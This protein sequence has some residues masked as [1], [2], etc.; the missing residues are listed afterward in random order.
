M[1]GEK[2]EAKVLEE[3][4]LLEALLAEDLVVAGVADAADESPS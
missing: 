1:E 4:F 3:V 2:E